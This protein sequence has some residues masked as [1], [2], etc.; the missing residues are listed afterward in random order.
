MGRFGSLC[1]IS[2][3][4]FQRQRVSNALMLSKAVKRSKHLY[5]LSS[6]AYVDSWWQIKTKLSIG[7]S[8]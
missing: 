5:R 2:Y 8:N 1:R 3:F 7:F 6:L 4:Q